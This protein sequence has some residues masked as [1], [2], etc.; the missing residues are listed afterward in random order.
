MRYNPRHLEQSVI[1]SSYSP[2][3]KPVNSRAR[4]HQSHARSTH[5]SQTL[6]LTSQTASIQAKRTLSS[7]AHRVNP[8]SESCLRDDSSHQAL[9]STFPQPATEPT[10]SASQTNS[11][12][13]FITI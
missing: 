9:S 2:K 7:A 1:I 4:S 13:C 8:K 10:R 6:T 11:S 5:T 3:K 12:Q